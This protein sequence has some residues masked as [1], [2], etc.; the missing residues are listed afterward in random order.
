M[1]YGKFSRGARRPHTTYQLEMIS[2]CLYMIAIQTFNQCVCYRHPGRTLSNS[3]TSFAM[4]V[5]KT[6]TFTQTAAC[7]LRKMGRNA[8]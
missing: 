8:V 5:S 2:W 7:S 6:Q 3:R 4:G 1:E